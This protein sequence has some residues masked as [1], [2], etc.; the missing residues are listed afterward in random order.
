[1]IRLCLSCLF[2][3]TFL[4]AN[5]YA[6]ESQFHQTRLIEASRTEAN[7]NAS[8]QLV[9]SADLNQYLGKIVDKITSSE[10]SA[11][12]FFRIH[13]LRNPLPYI[14]CLDNGAIYVSTGLIARLQNEA[15]LAGLLAPEMSSVFRQDAD[16]KNALIE[17]RNETKRMV[18]NLLAVVFTGG[19]AALPILSAQEK[20][21]NALNAKLQIETDDLAMQWLAN[22][23]FDVTQS[24]AAIARLIQT[25]K[26]EQRFGSTSLSN[27]AQLEKREP[28]LS[29]A[30]AKLSNKELKPLDDKYFKSILHKFGLE[31]AY[32]DK[33]DSNAER[34]F[35]VLARVESETG[36][37]GETAFLRAEYAREFST[38]DLQLS[39]ST[40]LYEDAI[41]FK[42]APAETWRELG[43]LYRKFENKE[44]A[45]KNL[46]EYLQKKSNA[47]DAPIIKI[48]IES[49]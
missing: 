6:A 32:S 9:N 10:D 16:S 2:L 43:L 25:L 48:Y 47:A 49:L 22:S 39:E 36:K 27:I 19:I 23:G 13:A 46:T 18:P 38:N 37:D 11:K 14:Y 12:G 41:K 7:Y 42:N 4:A 5:L 33:R 17:K 29:T 30:A 20:E 1:M 45:L 3:T 24:S 8:A 26:E 35:T 31:L 28:Q 21:T 40:K 34:F 44:A 15:Q